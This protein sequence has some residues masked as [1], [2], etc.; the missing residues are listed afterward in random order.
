MKIISHRGYWKEP[1]EKN[2]DVAFNRSFSL[3][4]GTETDVRDRKGQ[5]AV[6]HDPA[7]AYDMSLPSLLAM[8]PKHLLLALNIKADGLAGLL[9]EQLEAANI[10]EYFVFDMAVPDMRDYFRLEMPV[11]TRLSE[12]EKVPAYL[13]QA[14]GIWLDSF[15]AEWYG[16][17]EL[18][19]LLKLGKPICVVSADLHRRSNHAQWRLLAKFNH[20]KNITLC[21]DFPEQ[22]REYFT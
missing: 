7:T 6:A 14:T 4:F 2:R 12:V 5:L 19:E 21:T 20:W 15:G 18:E 17:A 22:A 16:E 9:K 1:L 3:E 11:Y 10:T 13:D 8:A